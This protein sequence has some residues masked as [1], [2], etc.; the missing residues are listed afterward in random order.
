MELLRVRGVGDEMVRWAITSVRPTLYAGGRTLAPIELHRMPSEFNYILMLAQSETE[1]LLTE[2][3]ARQGVKVE[4]GVEVTSLR[5][6][7][8]A[9]TVEV[10]LRD[11]EGARERVEASYVIGADGP[12]STRA[13]DRG[14][15]FPG[16][17]LPHHYV[18]ADLHIDGQVPEDQVSIFL[19]TGGFVAVFPMGAGRFRLMATDPAGA[20][21]RRGHSGRRAAAAT[22]R[23]RRADSRASARPELE[24][25]L[26]DQQQIRAHAAVGPG[27]PRR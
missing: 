8:A 16:R 13:Q 5:T 21:P 1:R 17:T 4:R 10:S 24:F 20:S 23:P 22:L 26:P 6:S 14:H 2:Q 3:L 9:D 11:A 25:P 7:A 18:L 15:S 12:H 27:V 19:A